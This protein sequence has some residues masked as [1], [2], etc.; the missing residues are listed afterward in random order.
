MKL[1]PYW[2]VSKDRVGAE[3]L[4]IAV[5]VVIEVLLRVSMIMLANP[6]KVVM[7]IAIENIPPV[8]VLY[9]TS[10]SYRSMSVE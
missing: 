6:M 1:D 8:T 7:M 10:S 9:S 2:V 5:W 4:L 3:L